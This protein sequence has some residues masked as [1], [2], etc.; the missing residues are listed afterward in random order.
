MILAACCALQNTAVLRPLRRYVDAGVVS[1]AGV[2]ASA[3]EPEGTVSVAAVESMTVIFA[4]R[5]WVF[6][7]IGDGVRAVVVGAVVGES[8]VVVVRGRKGVVLVCVDGIVMFVVGHAERDTH[9]QLGGLVEQSC[10]E[11]VSGL[12]CREQ[13]CR[14]KQFVSNVVVCKKL[15]KHICINMDANWQPCHKPV[16][17]P[18]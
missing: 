5:D 15:S 1:L 4:C 18:H 11:C 14:T 6:T 2:A 13:R 3:V 10:C 12:C 9:E 17:K 16:S 8:A 7:G